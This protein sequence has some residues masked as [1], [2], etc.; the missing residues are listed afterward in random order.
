MT[1][2]VQFSLG[3]VILCIGNLKV[4]FEN[5]SDLT[6]LPVQAFVEDERYAYITK[7]MQKE[8]IDSVS[9]KITSQYDVLARD[10]VSMVSST[11]LAV[12]FLLWNMVASI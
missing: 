1:V 10:M 7:E 9:E 11:I 2:Q 6:L 12:G 3:H 4:C 8:L 5:G